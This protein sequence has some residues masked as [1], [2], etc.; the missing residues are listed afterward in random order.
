MTQSH[1]HSTLNVL[2]KVKPI[3]L[4]LD[5]ESFAG[6]ENTIGEDQAVKANEARVIENWEAI[7]LGG[8]QRVAGVNKIADSDSAYTE[9]PD[10]LIYHDESGSGEIYGVIEGDLFIIDSGVITQ[11]D[12]AA[13]T[14]GVLCHAVS[15][16][17]SLW[18]TNSTDNLQIKTIGN[19]I[20]ATTD[21]PSTACDRIYTMKSRLF[22]EGGSRTIYGSRAGV[23]NWNAAD[24]WSLA[25]DAFSIDLPDATMGCAPEFPSGDELL[26]FTRFGA[27]SVYNFPNVA[28]RPIPNSRGCGAPLSIA[29]GDEGVFFV[30]RYPTLGV[31]LFNGVNFIELT[32]LNRDVFVEKIN[33]SSR[34]FGVY[35]NKKY[36]LIYN[37]TG[38]GVTYPNRIR[39]YDTRFG[40]WMSRPINE[41]LIDNMGYPTLLSKLNN[42]LYMASSGKDN[43]YEFEVGTDDAGVNTESNYKTKDFSSIDFR[44]SGSG[45]FPIDDVRMKLIKT[46]MTFYGTTG[47]VTVQWSADRGRI[48]GSQ[49]F[50]LTQEGD[51]INVDFIVNQSYILGVLP[52]KTQT[53]SFSNNAVGNRFNFQI[54]NSDS[55][56]L[57]K[58]KKIKIH[59]IAYEEN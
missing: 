36:Y 32:E 44:V 10:L 47:V 3:E 53:K 46:T 29:K 38:S 4:V 34:I 57:P 35:R 16:G 52:T 30:S 25:N 43:I 13:F 2:N 8:M 11:E 5:L 45:Q 58:V 51:L 17:D 39:I 15:A 49:T 55:G 22:A 21:Q 48:S 42:E 20:A 19:P 33:F 23:G 31:F 37:E 1:L 59:A 28:F 24:T 12:A 27:Y 54:L 18:I 50:D 41:S 40:R 6:G 7:S 26:S 56:T 9:A 14:S